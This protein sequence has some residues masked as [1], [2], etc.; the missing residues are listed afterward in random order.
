MA[1]NMT[2]IEK[3]LLLTEGTVASMLCVSKACLRKWRSQ[4]GRGPSFIRLAG[5]SA[6]RYPYDSLIEWIEKQPGGGDQNKIES[7]QETV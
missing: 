1:K 6:L 5:G 4:P 7:R 3:N 2:N